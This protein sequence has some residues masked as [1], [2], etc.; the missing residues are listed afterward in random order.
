MRSI[1]PVTA[2]ASLSLAVVVGGGASL[3]SSVPVA[4]AGT[5]FVV[6]SHG[7]KPDRE[8]GDGRCATAGD[9]AAARRCTARERAT[10]TAR[11]TRARFGSRGDMETYL[12]LEMVMKGNFGCNAHGGP[13]PLTHLP[14][15]VWTSESTGTIGDELG[16][17]EFEI[18]VE[19]DGTYTEDPIHVC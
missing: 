17:V 18:R 11:F 4:A 7:D 14:P 6:R 15:I 12:Y 16:A 1:R 5:T 2:L 13:D 19:P 9:T 8:P 3:V 10:S